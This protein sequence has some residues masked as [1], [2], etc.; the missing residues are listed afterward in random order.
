MKSSHIRATIGIGALLLG[1]VLAARQSG[2]PEI[3]GRY[4]LLYFLLLLGYL[5]GLAGATFF[6]L[7]GGDP[8]RGLRRVARSW[9]FGAILLLLLLPTV[10]VLVRFARG[11]DE[12][13][14]VRLL[15]LLS[16]S[17]GF[18]LAAIGLAGRESA[19]ALAFL[20][21]TALTVLVGIYLAVLA[22]T[23]V[24]GGWIERTMGLPAETSFRL[25]GRADYDPALL[26]RPGASFVFTG[27]PGRVRE[28]AVPVRNSPW[29]FHDR[30]RTFENPD[31]RAR[32]LVLGDGYVQAL[33]V[34]VES[35]VAAVLERRLNKGGRGPEVIPL[36]RRGIGQEGELKL[37]REFGERL[38]PQLVI[39]VWGTNDLLD[40]DPELKALATPL[41]GAVLF[42]GL[43]LDRLVA[44]WLRERL[45]LLD[46]RYRLG[47][48]RPDY[49]A[50]LEPTPAPVE[51]AFART[52]ALLDRIVEACEAME[53]ELLLVIKRPTNELRWLSRHPGLRGF[54]FDVDAHADWLA[55]YARSRDAH[56][57]D[58][59]PPFQEYYDRHP[60]GHPEQYSWPHSGM[61]NE[62]G[63]RLAAELIHEKIVRDG[64]IAV[65][66]DT[67]AGVR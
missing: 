60:T 32:V 7:A 21:G 54:D 37:L 29:G 47:V 34:P 18:A 51:A 3:L 67:A 6:W 4:S 58:L 14:L 9:A 56:F 33:E 61:L 66:P 53:A 64:L 12:L 26:N 50:Y 27:S 57:L 55:E 43:L 20:Q 35:G 39:L 10:A 13:D 59:G 44:K 1:V 16:L 48:L 19:R 42:P 40:N 41:P 23:P 11:G 31:G 46:E 62:A 63:H 5:P 22:I 65:S 38:R 25:T 45:Y 30:E 52:E 15:A 17:A 28:F 8:A 49:W 24:L 2:S 36:A